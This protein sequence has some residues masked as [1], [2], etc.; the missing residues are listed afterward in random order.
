MFMYRHTKPIVDVWE[1][2]IIRF[3]TQ[4]LYIDP[5]GDTCRTITYSSV[6]NV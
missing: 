3:A 6:H 4:V 5:D 1:K 2:V